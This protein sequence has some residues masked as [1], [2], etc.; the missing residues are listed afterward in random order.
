LIAE[1]CARKLRGTEALL[2]TPFVNGSGE[3]VTHDSVRRISEA[4]A[5]FAPILRERVGEDVCASPSWW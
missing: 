3:T 5:D 4:D 2:S 1:V